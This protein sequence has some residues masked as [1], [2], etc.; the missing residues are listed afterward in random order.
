MWRGGS[1]DTIDF[2]QCGEW[3]AGIKS[4]LNSVEG[5][6]GEG[7][8]DANDFSC[9]QLLIQQEHHYQEIVLVCHD[10]DQTGNQ[11]ISL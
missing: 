11:A 2:E 3:G 7:G 4:I 6:W 1:S 8:S 5:V 10:Q 9:S